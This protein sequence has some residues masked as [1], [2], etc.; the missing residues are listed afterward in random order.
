MAFVVSS[1]AG[2]VAGL[3]G[4]VIW[5]A[6]YLLSAAAMAAGPGYS[7]TENFLSDLGNPASPAPW[8]FNLA[9]ILAGLLAIP[10]GLALGG[11]LGGMWG[12]AAQAAI[13]LSGIALIGVGVYPEGSL[14][15]LHTTF[16][17]AFFLLLTIALG[18]LLRPMFASRAFSPVG[19]W[20]TAIAFVFA[21]AIVA[22]F[23]GRIGND[24]LAEHL[25]VYAALVWQ[26]STGLHLWRASTEA[27]EPLAAPA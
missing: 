1:R 5:T 21:V 8:A 11:K 3:A 22:T 17:L 19:A 2:A 16:S 9:D 23:I 24:H 26:T 15:G 20:V 27:A 13:V 7:I 18:L 14:Y 10:F 12:R 4:V 6:L 25:G